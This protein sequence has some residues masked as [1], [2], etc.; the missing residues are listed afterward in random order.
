VPIGSYVALMDNLV[1]PGA[2][3]AE[4]PNNTYGALAPASIRHGR[5]PCATDPKLP[6]KHAAI[7]VGWSMGLRS[8]RSMVMAR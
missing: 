1:V 4:M 6:W 7:D 2:T 3:A 8:L 5:G